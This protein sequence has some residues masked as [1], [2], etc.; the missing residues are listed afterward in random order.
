MKLS[1]NG[2]DS[3]SD[4]TRSFAVDIRYCSEIERPKCHDNRWVRSKAG[5]ELSSA[6]RLDRLSIVRLRNA[7]HTLPYAETCGVS[8]N[9]SGIPWLML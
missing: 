1:D 7:V 5:R 2:I 8:I 6:D 4:S 3:D 9:S